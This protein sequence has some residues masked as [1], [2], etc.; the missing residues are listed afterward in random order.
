MASE[1]VGMSE[2]K[3]TLKRGHGLAL[4]ITRTRN[5]GQ[6]ASRNKTHIANMH[7]STKGIS[8]QREGMPVQEPVV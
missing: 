3:H 1:M 6:N 2:N 4:C 8:R 5:W 7:G